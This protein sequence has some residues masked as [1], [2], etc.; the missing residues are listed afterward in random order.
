MDID[1]E[2]SSQG[3]SASPPDAAP[4]C[5]PPAPAPADLSALGPSAPSDR[6]VAIDVLRG[7]AL[8]GILLINSVRSP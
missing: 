5:P 7:F 8:L 1:R 4:A 6:I 3:P 2:L